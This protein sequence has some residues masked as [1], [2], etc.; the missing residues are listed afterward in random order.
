M[1]KRGQ[2]TIFIILAILIVSAFVIFFSLNK[3]SKVKTQENYPEEILEIKEFVQDCLIETAEN[4]LV[5][6]GE[7]GGYF[8]NLDYEYL[9]NGIPFYLKN[10]LKIIPTR[11]EIESELEYYIDNELFYCVIGLYQQFPEFTFEEGDTKSHIEIEE[12]EI[13]VSMDYDLTITKEDVSYQI[14]NY[15]TTISLNLDTLLY[16]ADEVVNKHLEDPE[17]IQLTALYDLGEQTEVYI[18]LMDYEGSLVYSLTD[19]D[20]EINNGTYT[21]YLAIE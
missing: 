21:W 15:E 16:V 5:E 4:G 19:F 9:G 12:D 11:E 6:I 7:T 1:N 8:S 18:D 13:K 3:D 14:K 10:N 20:T 2:V 17:N